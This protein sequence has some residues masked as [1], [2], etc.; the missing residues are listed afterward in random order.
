MGGRSEGVWLMINEREVINE[1]WGRDVM[2]RSNERNNSC[3]RER[4]DAGVSVR[5][6]GKDEALWVKVRMSHNM[7]TK[8]GWSDEDEEDWRE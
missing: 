6:E 7:N 3:P 2:M 1:Q 8:G 5:N 4:W